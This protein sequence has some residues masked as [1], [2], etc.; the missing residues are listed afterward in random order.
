ML[1]RKGQLLRPL[2]IS[3][4]LPTANHQVIYPRVVVIPNANR[5]VYSNVVHKW[6]MAKKELNGIFELLISYRMKAG[7]SPRLLI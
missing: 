1:M 7:P 3:L 5:A 2:A 6:D 4:A